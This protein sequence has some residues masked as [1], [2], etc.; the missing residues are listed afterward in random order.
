MNRRWSCTNIVIKKR[1]IE[2]LCSFCEAMQD[3][4][5]SKK[6]ATAAS[7]ES[8]V[9]DR[10]A[11]HTATSDL[12]SQFRLLLLQYS[13]ALSS[14]RYLNTNST[15]LWKERKKEKGPSFLYRNIMRV[16]VSAADLWH[17]RRVPVVLE[18]VPYRI[19]WD[20]KW[21]FSPIQRRLLY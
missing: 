2:Y 20:W 4:V 18:V 7:T 19:L 15:P 3:N 8:I 17:P 21:F 14:S 11:F 10:L 6:K 12:R 5:C 13:I 16:F 1:Y 9:S